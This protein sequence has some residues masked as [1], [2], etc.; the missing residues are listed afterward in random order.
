MKSQ[1]YTNKLAA[2]NELVSQIQMSVVITRNAKDAVNKAKA[3]K[4]LDFAQL[5]A[6]YKDAVA[7]QKEILVKL[8]NANVELKAMKAAGTSVVKAVRTKKEFTIANLGDLKSYL[9]SHNIG[10]VNRGILIEV[11][12]K[13]VAFSHGHF[14]VNKQVVNPSVLVKSL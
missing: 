11:K 9:T 4:T 5:K 7:V 8:H 14:Y 3:E 1:E 2:K 6:E 13:K 10:F 12:D